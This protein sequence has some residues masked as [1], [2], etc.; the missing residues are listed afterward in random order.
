MDFDAT[1]LYPS[2]MWDENSVYP[3]IESG[4]DFKPYMNDVYLKSLNDQTFNQE[5][6]ESAILKIKFYDP[7]NLNFQH[8]PVKEKAKN[9]GYSY[10]KWLYYR[11]FN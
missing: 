2:A 9:K 6:D 10:E 1:S 7:P 8:P 4:F 5:G 3:K 11:Y